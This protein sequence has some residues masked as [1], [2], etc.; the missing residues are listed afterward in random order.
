MDDFQ[1][2]SPACSLSIA[3][4][5]MPQDPND[6][7]PP[8]LVLTGYDHHAGSHVSPPKRAMKDLPQQILERTESESPVRAEPEGDVMALRPGS[9]L[10]N[11]EIRPLVPEKILRYDRNVKVPKEYTEYTIPPVTTSFDRHDD[12]PG[13]TP[14]FHPEGAL[15]FCHEEK[16]IFTDANLYEP[17]MLSQILADI[18]TIEE[19]FRVHNMRRAANV[20]L[21]LE[22]RR[23]D[24]QIETFYYMVD[25][26]K[27]CIFF[28]DEFNAS[29]LPIWD[30]LQGTS[31]PTHVK[32]EIETQYWYHCRL[33]P[34]SLELTHDIV[35]ELRDVVIHSMGDQII[36]TTSTVPYSV[37]DL[38][39]MLTLANS[40][41]QDV[42]NK[43]QGSTCVV[44]TLM[45]VFVRERFYN[46]H[47]QPGAR[48]GYDQ[49]VYGTGRNKRSW[50]V[51]SLSPMLFFA[52]EVHLRALEKIWVDGI[53]RNIL[54]TQFLDKLYAEWQEF[55]LYGTVLLNAN[56]ALLTIQSVDAGRGAGRSPAQI[57]SYAS[58]GAS[59]GA[60]ILGLL[61]VRQNRSKGRDSAADASR[62]LHRRSNKVMGMETLAIMF[63]LPYAL[64]MWAMVCFLAA[65]LFVCFDGSDIY[66]RL[67]VGATWVAIAALILCCIWMGWEPISEPE[68]EGADPDAE[69]KTEANTKE[70]P[71]EQLAVPKP[72]RIGWG[73]R[74]LVF[75]RD[76]DESDTTVVWQ[77]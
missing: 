38:Q 24:G 5:H 73:W 56:V 47:G 37:D 14:F 4:S 44:A 61:L 52:P 57:A 20:D 46:F 64:L 17:D 41:K 49:S 55:T 51:L 71:N 53:T 40:I 28:V 50:L 45:Y 68:V 27:R 67:L 21:V 3:A 65:F 31:S 39:K 60:I 62:F 34:N 11:P 8:A 43:F 10:S 66:T 6:A 59:I 48:M 36:S 9:T 75:R 23:V 1:V 26:S 35:N 22:L 15:Y 13:W 16:R 70:K 12:P 74:A 63:A 25:H 18:G 72:S 76:S 32:H 54:W 77:V 30:E 69:P 29:D 33:Y 42:D 2:S 58:I 19:F 7:R